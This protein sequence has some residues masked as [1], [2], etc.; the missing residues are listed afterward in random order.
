M[1]APSIAKVRMGYISNNEH[2][3]SQC[4]IKEFI[5]RLDADAEIKAYCKITYLQPNAPR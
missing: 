5:S 2:K 1:T 4:R 3:K